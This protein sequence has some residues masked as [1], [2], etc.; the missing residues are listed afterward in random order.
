[1]CA[2][3]ELNTDWFADESFW[4]DLHPFLFSDQRREAAQGEVD[5]VLALIGEVPS[6]LLDLCCGPGRHSVAFARRGL[7]VTG[8]D[9]SPFLLS[10]AREYAAAENARVEWVQSDMRE[11]VRPA[12]FDAAV[13]LFTSFGYFD[14]ERDNVRVLANV[15]ESLKPG[16]TFVIDLVGKELVARVFEATGSQEVPGA[17]L[18][19]QRRRV[20]DDWCRIEN[21][22]IVVKD[23][24]ARSY[25]FRHWLY[26]ARELRE[27]LASV[28]F[29]RIRSFGDLEGV[30]YGIAARRLVAVARKPPR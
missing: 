19:V 16:G 12:C 17:G 27:L 26:S 8:V 29:E 10:R 7:E 20:I 18:Q 15:F 25:R 21:E 22:W 23:G 11:F 14:D 28:G 9:R 1:M 13:N 3:G 6:T 24:L 4:Q 2:M 5:A 30:E